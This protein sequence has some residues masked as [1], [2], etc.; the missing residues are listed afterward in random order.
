MRFQPIIALALLIP[1][2]LA[3]PAAA[4]QDERFYGRWEPASTSAIGSTVWIEA[5]GYLDILGAN[6][7]SWQVERY[8]VIKD[9]GP[10]IVVR[11]WDARDDPFIPE[12][13][14]L[15]VLEIYDEDINTKYWYR[16]LSYQYCYSIPARK[17]IF[18][19]FDAGNIWRRA[20]ELTSDASFDRCDIAE[21]GTVS[22]N[23]GGMGWSQKMT[24]NAGAE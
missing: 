8:R 22:G 17:I 6:D 16:I 12:N 7:S 18:Q 1:G 21:D 14:D 24:P 2:A 20:R 11:L 13:N 15:I 23:W 9:F 19:D 3:T 4:Q 5:D 10:R